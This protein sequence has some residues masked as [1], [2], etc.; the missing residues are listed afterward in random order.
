MG[1]TEFA[2]I[3]ASFCVT[4]GP[5]SPCVGPVQVVTPGGVPPP[6]STGGA[7][8]TK[9]QAGVTGNA[10][11]LVGEEGEAGDLFVQSYAQQYC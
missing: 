2:V 11:S 8:Q 1:A 6:A 10:C 9:S 5:L 7:A 4:V 3:A